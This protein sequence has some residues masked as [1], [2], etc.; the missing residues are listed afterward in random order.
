MRLEI[1]ERR[2]GKNPTFGIACDRI[3]QCE[4]RGEV[5]RDRIDVEIGEIPAQGVGLRFQEITGNID[6]YVGAEGAFVQQQ[7][8]FGG[9]AGAEFHQRG[10][11]R[12]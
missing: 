4:R 12:E 11:F 9:R 10:T 3:R 6:R 7:P 8:D 2:P 1:P 5:G